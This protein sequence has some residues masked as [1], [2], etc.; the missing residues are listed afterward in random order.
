M[1]VESALADLCRSNHRPT[2]IAEIQ[3]EISLLQIYTLVKPLRFRKVKT[4]NYVFCE[5]DN[6]KKSVRYW[7][8]L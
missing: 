8:K 4:H 6:I 7:K 1:T 5:E 2:V 3:K